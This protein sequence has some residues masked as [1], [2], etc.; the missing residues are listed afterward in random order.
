MTLFLFKM[1]MFDIIEK[2]I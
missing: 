1:N 2:N